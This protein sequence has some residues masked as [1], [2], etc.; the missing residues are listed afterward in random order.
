MGQLRAYPPPYVPI[1][2]DYPQKGGTATGA[3]GTLSLLGTPGGIDYRAGYLYLG[4]F[5][6][7]GSG[8]LR[9]VDV[10]CCDA[11][12][13]VGSLTSASLYHCSVVKV[14]GTY[15]FC[16]CLDLLT[17]VD[18]SNPSAP[19]VLSTVALSGGGNTY[20]LE[21]VGQY[22]YAWSHASGVLWV[23]DVSNPSAPVVVAS[24][25]PAGGAPVYGTWFAGDTLYATSEAGYLLCLDVSNPAAPTL[26]GSLSGLGTLRSFC[27]VGRTAFCLVYNAGLAIRAVNVSN[28]AAPA[29]LS[30]LVLPYSGFLST[31]PLSRDRIA[32]LGG[33]GLVVLDVSTP[34]AMAQVTDAVGITGAVDMIACG[35]WIY[36]V[37]TVL[38]FYRAAI[39]D[40]RSAQFLSASVG[41]AEAEDLS[42]TGVLRANEIRADRVSIG[43][44]GLVDWS[45]TG[46][47]T[48][49]RWTVLDKQRGGVGTSQTYT[50]PAGTLVRVE[51]EL[52][53]EAWGVSDVGGTVACSVFGTT[54]ASFVAGAVAAYRIRLRLILDSAGNV[55]YVCTLEGDALAAQVVKEGTLAADNG[56]IVFQSGTG[57]TQKVCSTWRVTA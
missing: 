56:A 49:G 2:G 23:V 5:G 21:I 53:A 45:R 37:D 1:Q 20:A 16:G 44:G 27:V 33:G 13:I 22:V 10:S 14:A 50:V 35:R 31:V 36:C 52:I 28:P 54:V 41:R 43:P 11:P 26:T 48:G 30:T 34:T 46:G 4:D 38:G 47:G 55:S 12:A 6:A 42:V 7:G 8:G 9:I 32:L 3:T 51:D 29:L 40:T 24:L 15:A 19:V 17:V 25:T 18:V 39:Y 57:G